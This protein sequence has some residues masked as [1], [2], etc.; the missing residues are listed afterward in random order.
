MASGNGSNAERIISFFRESKEAEVT[1]IITN[2]RKA[3]VLERC[4]RLGV[5]SMI[6]LRDDFYIH[7]HVLKQL[8]AE[9]PDLIILAGFL[10][11]VPQ[12]ILHA[13]PNKVINIHPALLP[14]YGGKGMY[15]HHVHEAVIKAKESQSGITIHY[16]NE[17]YDD[18]HVIFQAITSL[19]QQDTPESLAQKI[20]QLEY[21]HFPEVIQSLL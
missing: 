11:L 15:G 4:Q 2:N 9:Q 13:F 18:G 21:K 17:K 7:H 5:P 1:L 12:E 8:I 3:G 14:K 6:A 20:H 19:S 16:V 10:W